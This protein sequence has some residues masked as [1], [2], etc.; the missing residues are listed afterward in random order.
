MRNNP[1]LGIILGLT[2]LG[3]FLFFL[4]L[5]IEFLLF[6][7]PHTD[8]SFNFFIPFILAF[9][10]SFAFGILMEIP[11]IILFSLGY[12]TFSTPTYLGV[13]EIILYASINT[14]LIY[15]YF[16][17]APKVEIPKIN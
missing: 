9:P 10:W 13:F 14:Y 4:Y 12:T 3:I 5:D 8:A 1:T 15:R 11:N 16:S 7:P 17:T 6:G 2:Y